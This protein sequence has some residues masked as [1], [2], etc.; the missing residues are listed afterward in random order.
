MDTLNLPGTLDSLSAI[1]SYVKQAADLAGI[2]GKRS[3]RLRLAVDEI[4][5]NIV[6]HGYQEHDMVGEIEIS[7]IV[8]DEN[9]TVRMKD[10]APYFNPLGHPR[11][12]N[13][14]LPIEARPYGGL[15]VYLAV[16]NVDHFNY[17]Y[18]DGCNYNTLVL[19]RRD[20]RE[21]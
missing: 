18:V 17:E 10:T 1:R 16:Q 4:A 6:I 8:D 9:L 2:D 13:L 7:A 19:S 20:N 12:D 15:G 21:C 3:Y 5:T 14:A 11:P